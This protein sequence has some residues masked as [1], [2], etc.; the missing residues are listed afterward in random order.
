MAYFTFDRTAKELKRVELGEHMAREPLVSVLDEPKGVVV[1][2]KARV[3]ETEGKH[4]GHDDDFAYDRDRHDEISEQH[5]QAL[6]D[7]VA[8][9]REV[10]KKYNTDLETNF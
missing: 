9:G 3:P 7:A 2:T 8:Y 4:F 10:A 1:L 6:R 5:R